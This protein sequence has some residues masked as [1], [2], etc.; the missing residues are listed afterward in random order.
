MDVSIVGATGYTGIELIKA[1]MDHPGVQLQCLTTRQKDPAPLRTLAP[2]LPKSS[3]L[4]LSTFNFNEVAKRSDVVFLALPHTEAVEFGEKFYRR[5]KIV[6]DLSADFRLKDPAHYRKWYNFEHG[7]KGL[8]KHAVYGL[9][10]YYREAIARTDLIANPGC[11][12]TGVLLGL[13][14]LIEQKLIETDSIV[15][16]CKTGVSGAGRKLS[17]ATHFCEVTEDFKAYKVTGHQHLPEMEQVLAEIA[18]KKVKLTF[19]P[20]LLPLKRGILSTLYVKLKRQMTE[21]KV[22]KVFYKRYSEE[23]FVRVLPAGAFPSL[24]GVTNTNFCDI[25]VTVHQ[26][27]KTA[28]VVTAIDNLLKGA[29]GQAV[30]NMNIRTGF[31]ED[32]A[33]L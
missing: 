1:L 6:I 20:H 30:Q 32:T 28:V 5:G 26:A 23:P 27:T 31:P 18:K 14:P 4:G 33:L 2:F 12:P 7:H 29:S 13:G 19:I 10:E 9:P 8:L 17:P 15:A 21:S 3:G 16:D 25:G 22:L 11:F 24:A